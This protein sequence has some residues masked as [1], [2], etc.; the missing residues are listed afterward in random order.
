[1]KNDLNLWFEIDTIKSVFFSF[2]LLC[3]GSL[4]LRHYV[5]YSIKVRVEYDFPTTAVPD[6]N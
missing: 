2:L 5:K 4:R 1:M 3:T 6:C